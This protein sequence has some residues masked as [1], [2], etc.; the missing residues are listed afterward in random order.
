VLRRIL[1]LFQ[2]QPKTDDAAELARKYAECQ[3]RI[4]VMR[5]Q[6]ESMSRPFMGFLDDPSHERT[7]TET[8][9]AALDLI[10]LKNAL[11]AEVARSDELEKHLAAVGQSG[12]SLAPA[13]T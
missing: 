3:A 7:Q 9:L 6:L 13:T 5:D 1:A 8:T 10:Q 4:A 11:R 12:E 2:S